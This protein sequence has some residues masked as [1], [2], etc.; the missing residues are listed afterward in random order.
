MLWHVASNR[1]SAHLT[2]ILPVVILTVS[3]TTMAFSTTSRHLKRP[4]S[5]CGPPRPNRELAKGKLATFKQNVRTYDCNFGLIIHFTLRHFVL[6]VTGRAGAG[7]GPSMNGVFFFT[8]PRVSRPCWSQ[9][10]STHFGC[11]GDWGKLIPS[12]DLRVSIKTI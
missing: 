10:S 6:S 12:L 3:E 1:F 2:T 8:E 4:H 11:R 9:N 5:S 7:G